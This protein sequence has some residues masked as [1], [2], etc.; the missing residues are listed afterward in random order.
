[1]ESEAVEVR[2]IARGLALLTALILATLLSTVR[3]PA[4]PAPGVEQ[5]ASVSVVRKRGPEPMA[6][7]AAQAL[8]PQQPTTLSAVSA[9]SG[10]GLGQ[11]TRLWVNG[12]GGEIVFRNAGRF[13][14]CVLARRQRMED[15]DCPSAADRRRMVLDTDAEGARDA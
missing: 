11:E 9:E 3:L 12:P 1:M 7:A 8:A 10:Q 14:R 13:E 6:L 4:A 15:A 5:E 2:A